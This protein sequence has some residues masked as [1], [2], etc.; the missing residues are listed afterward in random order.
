MVDK[1]INLFF[2]EVIGNYYKLFY[3]GEFREMLIKSSNWI[4][5][6]F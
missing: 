5:V 4:R 6:V 1:V 3:I 2:K